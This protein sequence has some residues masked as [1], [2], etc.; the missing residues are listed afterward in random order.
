MFMGKDRMEK[1]KVKNTSGT[2]LTRET[3]RVKRDKKGQ[4]QKTIS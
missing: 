4:L 3:T 2:A 1:N